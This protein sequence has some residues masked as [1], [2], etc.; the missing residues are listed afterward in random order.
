MPTAKRARDESKKKISTD[1]IA[2]FLHS[3]EN[4]GAYLLKSCFRQQKEYITHPAKLKAVLCSRRA[5][6]TYSS[7][8]YLIKEAMENPGVSILY[9]GLTKESAKS[10]IFKDVVKQILLDKGLTEG[11][12]FHIKFSPPMLE[13]A[14]GS[15]IYIS[16]ADQN[17]KIANNLLGNKYKLIVIDECQSWTQDL[18]KIIYEILHPTTLDLG[19]TICMIGYPDL[20][21]RKK[22]LPIF[23]AVTTGKHEGLKWELF[24][25]N[26]L[27]NNKKPPNATKTVAESHIE[28]LALIESQNP[29]YKKT[30]PYFA[31]YLGEWFDD[32]NRLVYKYD[33]DINCID[34]LPSSEN[35]YYYVMGLDL[36]FNDATAFIISAYSEYDKRLYFIDSFKKEGMIIDDVADKIQEFKDKYPIHTI[37]VDNASKQVVET[38]K[39]RHGHHMIAAEKQDKMHYINMMN[40]DLMTAI[41]KIVGNKCEELKDEWRSCVYDEKNEKIIESAKNENHLADAALY[42]WRYSYNYL[43]KNKPV[44]VDRTSNEYEEKMLKDITQ[45]FERRKREECGKTQAEIDFD[46]KFG[47]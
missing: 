44:K 34:K 18:E 36:G 8:V 19:G 26:T 5:G 42:A 4:I 47:Y 43:A 40:S 28:R 38:L 46:T 2:R 33:Q 35:G 25:W 10:V 3:P 11:I 29:L 21:V 7:G 37:V 12:D 14:N 32:L 22:K 16:G 13:F 31:N 45:K 24:K 39:Q 20:S 9:L 1:V 27:D 6:K 15:I 41:I 30:P 17:F 23:Y